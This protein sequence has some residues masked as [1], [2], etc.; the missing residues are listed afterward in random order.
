MDNKILLILIIIFILLII[1]HRKREFFYSESKCDTCRNL[2]IHSSV[3]NVNTC[4]NNFNITSLR[5]INREDVYGPKCLG[6]CITE[7]IPKIN[8]D[9]AL[10]ES[11]VDID[12]L[13]FNRNNPSDGFCHSLN[14]KED[15]IN[16]CVGE[17]V[18][19][20][21][22][23]DNCE[24]KNNMCGEKSLNYLSGGSVLNATKCSFVDGENVGC[25]NNYFK[26]IETIKK[27]YDEEVEKIESVK[28]V[29]E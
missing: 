28:C 5:N 18:E 16:K 12:I 29:A 22:D 6:T 19:K 27:I 4:C 21:N 9:E 11:N 2:Q 3:G 13:K 15:G 10:N 20:C 1:V 14:S 26:S 25:V 23:E 24:I 7:H 8:F 17:C